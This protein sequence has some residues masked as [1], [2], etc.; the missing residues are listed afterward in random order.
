MALS[1]APWLLLGLLVAGLIRPLIPQTLMQRWLGGHG[2]GAV[3]R[4]AVIGA[5][6]PLCSCG[7]IPTALA[8]YRG[9]AGRGPT[10]AFMIS[11]PGVGVDS[12]L[13]TY[14]LLGPLMVVAR[15]L[16][17]LFT[18]FVTGLLVAGAGRGRTRGS[19]GSSVGLEVDPEKCND[20]GCAA[21]SR[22]GVGGACQNGPSL[23][24]PQAI[25]PATSLP[26]RLRGGLRYAFT[27][28]LDDISIW[29][30]IGVI[31]AGT[32]L[33]LAPPAVIANY[34]SGL[35]IMLLMAVVGIPM[36]MCATA[37]TPIAAGMLL[38]GVSPGAVLVFLVA[39]PVTSLATLGVLRR[40]M[41][42]VILLVYLGGILSSTL[43]LG[44]FA[45]TV[46]AATGVDIAAGSGAA[47]EW[48][49]AAV[50]WLAL[51]ALGVLAVPALRRR[52]WRGLQWLT[53]G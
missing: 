41:G 8:L 25:R 50:E 24:Q 40:E 28:L 48:M 45:E 46:V 19:V 21:G 3:A 29:I 42:P 37:A 23:A 12:L 52:V 5:P 18:A 1:V 11:T 39:A 6:L 43:A 13:L 4:G 47:R 27:D 32:L 7:A 30:A 9:G 53:T 36:Y 34:G 15:A 26:G 51:V 44:L 2:C 17:A 14:A 49:P 31:V 38:S 33:A 20:G 35:P 22:D 16:G 10:A